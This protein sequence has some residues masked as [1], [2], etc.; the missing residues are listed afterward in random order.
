M[1]ANYAMRKSRMVLHSNNEVCCFG[2]RT[3][4]LISLRTNDATVKGGVVKP[5]SGSWIGKEY[6]R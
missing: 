5:E 2:K 3:I 4:A 6:V 1:D